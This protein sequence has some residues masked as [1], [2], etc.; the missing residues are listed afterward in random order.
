MQINQLKIILFSLTWNTYYIPCIVWV[1]SKNTWCPPLSQMS[2]NQSALL[3]FHG[4]ALSKNSLSCILFHLRSI[5]NKRSWDPITKSEI[6]QKKDL[7]SFGSWLTEPHIAP[8]SQFPFPSCSGEHCHKLT[9]FQRAEDRSYSVS[10]V[11]VPCTFCVVEEL[12]G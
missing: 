5:P 10:A 11:T 9:L 1:L 12:G 4:S 6:R 3:Y 2:W 7:S 8:H